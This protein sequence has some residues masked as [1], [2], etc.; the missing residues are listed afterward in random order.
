MSLPFLNSSSSSLSL[1]A[2][3][4]IGAFGMWWSCR[5]AVIRAFVVCLDFIIFAMLAYWLA[6]YFIYLS[7]G[8]SGWVG[9]IHMSIYDKYWNNNNRGTTQ[10][11]QLWKGAYF[12]FFHPPLLFV[13]CTISSERVQSF[14]GPGM[15]LHEFLLLFLFCSYR[16]KWK[17]LVFPRLLLMC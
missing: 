2:I 4:T 8:V 6:Q 3:L 7:Y 10:T 11:P 17:A 13:Y 12:P 14:F 1:S 5:P 15:H 9:V 16:V